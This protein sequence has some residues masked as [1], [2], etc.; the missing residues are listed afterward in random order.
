MRGR[1]PISA[2][3]RMCGCRW[4]CSRFQWQADVFSHVTPLA[5]NKVTSIRQAGSEGLEIAGKEVAGEQMEHTL[6]GRSEQ[7]GE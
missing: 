2:A 4:S 3:V 5:F 6:P 7:R 1:T